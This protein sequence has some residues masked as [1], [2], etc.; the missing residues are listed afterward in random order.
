M[1][2]YDSKWDLIEDPD[3]NKGSL[4]TKSQELY[5]LYTVTKEG[6]GEY[7]TIKE[8]DTGGEDVEW[9]WSEEPEGEWH[10]YDEEG[11]EW[12]NPPKP[13]VEEWWSEAEANACTATWDLYTPYTAEE[14]AE[15]EQAAQEAAEAEA[16]AQEQAELIAMLPDLLAEMSAMMMELSADE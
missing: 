15:R 8:Y 4:E 1:A 5:A 16:K 6:V 9:R 12:A 7:V 2:T 13:A 10:F 14:L 3:L 11:T